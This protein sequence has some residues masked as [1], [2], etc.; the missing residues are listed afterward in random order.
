MP[1][2]LAPEVLK[3]YKSVVYLQ[4]LR[5]FYFKLLTGGFHVG[6]SQSR[7]FA[8]EKHLKAD[9]SRI[10]CAVNE[11]ATAIGFYDDFKNQD[12]NLLAPSVHVNNV[13][14]HG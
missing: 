1:L 2:L 6:V 9:K 12:E 11:L 4:E 5:G 7:W 8:L 13:S 3:G 10:S 14:I